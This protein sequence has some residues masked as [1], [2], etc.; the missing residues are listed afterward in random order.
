MMKRV[1]SA[2]FVMTLMFVV[3]TSLFQVRANE[4]DREVKVMTYNMYLGADLAPIFDQTLTPEQVFQQVG[5][6]FADMEAG[7]VPERIEE[8]ADQIASESPD[9]VG[10]QE[11]A[12][13]RYGTFF[14]PA[15]SQTVAYDFLQILLDELAERGVHY[16]PIAI[17]TNLD[18]E[19]P[20]I[21]SPTDV[22]DI[23]Y[24]DRVVIL[25]RTD[26][27]TSRLKIEGTASG[28][29]QTLL[30]VPFLG[31]TIY[32]QRGWTLADVKHRGKT[33]RF[34]NAHTEA[35]NEL[36]QYYQTLE[37]LGGPAATEGTVIL[38]G[39]FNSNAAAGGASYLLMLG[40]GF[41]DVWSVLEAPNT[42][43]T[44]PL[45][46]EDPSDFLTPTERLDLIL[47][48]GDLTFS[49]IDVVGEDP[50]SD[51][52]TSGLRPSDHAGV[53]ATVVLQP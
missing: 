4:S 39:D 40:Q 13:W 10:L 53:T 18:A 29:F 37:I 16:E 1:K 12:L 8:I 46:Y 6:A 22:R 9:L 45:Y 51:L 38:V 20:G 26:L 28:T 33:Y 30:P 24:T 7:S 25:A 2:G 42:G 36:V 52:T 49:D 32:V 17:Q 15:P 47:A 34:V 11:V 50:V 21:I 43:L 35:F 31:R 19:V 5:A 3:S 41:T 48:R 27:Q 14:D 44:W 23:R